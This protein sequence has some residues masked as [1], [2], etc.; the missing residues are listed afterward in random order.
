MKASQSSIYRKL[1]KLLGCLMQVSERIP[2]H[3][4][5]LQTVAARCINETIDALSV[6]EYALNT[7]DISQRVEYIAALIH[8]MTIIKTIVR[9]LH[10]YSK[11]E[12]V[13][14][15]NTPEGAKTVKQPR[16]GRIIS[17]SQYP[18][19]LR[20]FDELAR[21]TGAW[22]KSSLAMLSSQEVDMF[23]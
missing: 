16:Y 23:G 8:S 7:S 4:A 3:A 10:E 17:N 22:Y 14:M 19:F 1:E 13:S 5:G 6:C 9:Q 15:I 12:S 21:R 18:M 20:D 11:K 2:K